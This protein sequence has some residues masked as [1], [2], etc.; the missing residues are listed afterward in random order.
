MQHALAML[1]FAI[2]LRWESVDQVIKDHGDKAL[3]DPLTPGTGAWHLHHIVEIFREHARVMMDDP[4]LDTR[5]IPTKPRAI[6]DALLADV[7]GFCAW[8][9]TQPADLAARP[10]IYGQTMPFIEM[11]AGTVQHITWHAAAVHYWT[12]WRLPGPA[13]A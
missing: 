12:K 11:L 8:V 10:I 1:R 13:N 3:G 6:R 2:T 4:N 7:D 5:P 9:R